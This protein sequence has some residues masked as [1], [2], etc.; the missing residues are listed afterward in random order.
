MQ[1]GDSSVS[2]ERQI[3]KKKPKKTHNQHP[4]LFLKKILHLQQTALVLYGAF[5]SL[6]FSTVLLL[7]EGI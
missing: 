7:Y 6:F 5:T 2:R 4:K 3:T 1:L